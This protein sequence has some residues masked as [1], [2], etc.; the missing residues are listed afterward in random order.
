M[1][2]SLDPH[3]PI[4]VSHGTHVAIVTFNCEVT[5]QS[6]A[7]LTEAIDH[8][9]E[10]YKYARIELRLLSPGGSVSSLA[11]YLSALE[12]WQQD[13][14]KIDTRAL[15]DVASA[16]AIML[17]LGEYRTASKES[18]LLY[19]FARAP[20]LHNVTKKRAQE[21]GRYLHDVDED[22]V[23]RLVKRALKIIP[24]RKGA[25][26][27]SQKKERK[28][29]SWEERWSQPALPQEWE[30]FK[31]VPLCEKK[32]KDRFWGL[33]TERKKQ[34]IFLQ[35]VYHNVFDI[36]RRIPT[37]LAL[38]IGLIDEIGDSRQRHEREGGFIEIPEWSALF[39]PAGSV[40]DK[41]LTRHC[42][43]FGE[44]G[45]GKTGSGVLPVVN[46]IVNSRR[47]QIGF[48]LIIDPK[49]DI[50]A[51][52]RKM[53][54]ANRKVFG[55]GAT[56][57]PPLPLI[58]VI[59]SRNDREDIE[60]QA[61]NILKKVAKLTTQNPAQTLLGKPS[62]ARHDP[63]LE[64]KGVEVATTALM[65]TLWATRQPPRAFL[66]P[67]TEKLLNDYI[68]QIKSQ[69]TENKELTENK[70]PTEKEINNFRRQLA[71]IDVMA[72][73]RSPASLPEL[74]KSCS[75][76]IKRLRHD[77]GLVLQQEVDGKI[78]IDELFDVIALSHG[79]LDDDALEESQFFEFFEQPWEQEPGEQEPGEQASQFDAFLR[80]IVQKPEDPWVGD[81]NEVTIGRIFGDDIFGNEPTTS[82]ELPRLATLDLSKA[83]EPFFGKGVMKLNGESNVTVVYEPPCVFGDSPQGG[84]TG[85]STKICGTFLR[86]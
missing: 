23:Q 7:K 74:K 50:V 29:S 77:H 8:L 39:P 12:R 14:V 42:M 80:W 41:D 64:K 40:L 62:I 48:A 63:F 43:I 85:S 1:D 20:V 45:S 19:H 28:V 18:S 47:S 16:S 81:V 70:E 38:R 21:L 32:W 66:G 69:P 56:D 9:I 11:Y 33:K 67:K 78:W 72:G 59:N 17:S 73:L 30:D 76:L 5:P 57:G 4:S 46:A 71:D 82:S 24:P 75:Q 68:D 61:Q 84:E 79:E 25:G 22:I 6:I 36:D 37:E 15:T 44:T 58:N 31:V 52:M 27:P 83:S 49:H 3:T 51:A 26:G 2:I 10:T 35:E 54:R 60:T 13:A 34:E 53:K 65:L 86:Q 55:A